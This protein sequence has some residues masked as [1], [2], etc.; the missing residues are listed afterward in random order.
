MIFITLVLLL[1]SYVTIGT[2]KEYNL[3]KQIEKTD[4]YKKWKMETKK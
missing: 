1:I 2:I 3:R 4:F